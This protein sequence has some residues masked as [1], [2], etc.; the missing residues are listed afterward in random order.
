MVG[1]YDILHVLDIANENDLVV[2]KLILNNSISPVMDVIHE[3]RFITRK[4]V[5]S[6]LLYSAKP[7][8]EG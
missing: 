8:V 1:I 4:H 6:G 3:N 7:T 2:F 5:V